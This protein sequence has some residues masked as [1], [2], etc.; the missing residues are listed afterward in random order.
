MQH[1]HICAQVTNYSN[2]ELEW[3]KFWIVAVVG[4]YGMCSRS[5]PDTQFCLTDRKNKMQTFFS[6]VFE[7]YVIIVYMAQW[8]FTP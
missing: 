4:P 8:I 3:D 1:L 2:T 5:V 6:C 7:V